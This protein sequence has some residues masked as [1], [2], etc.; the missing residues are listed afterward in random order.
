MSRK[1]SYNVISDQKLQDLK[2]VK[3]A[4]K[5]R[6]SDELG[7]CAYNDWRNYKLETFKYDFGIYNADLNQLDTLTT[8]NFE[9]SMCR[10][11]PE[12]TKQKG[13]GPYLGKTAPNG[14]CDTK[15]FE[16]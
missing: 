14:C 2:Q 11:L 13:T 4:K 5:I 8:E 3:M 9:Y 10:F 6:K 15:V 12:V 1:C 7:V 16:Y